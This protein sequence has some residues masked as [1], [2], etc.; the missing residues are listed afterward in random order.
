MDIARCVIPKHITRGIVTQM[1]IPSVF[2]IPST[3]QHIVNIENFIRVFK[4]FDRFSVDSGL[5]K[6]YRKL[7]NGYRQSDWRLSGCSTHNV[8][9]IIVKGFLNVSIIV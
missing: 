4:G 1:K 8:V 6:G 3:N 2:C 5:G 7:R 9:A